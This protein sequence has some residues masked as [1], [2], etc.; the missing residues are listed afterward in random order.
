MKTTVMKT[1]GIKALG[2]L[3]LSLIY[4]YHNTSAGNPA[5]AVEY[6]SPESCKRRQENGVQYY[7]N[8]TKLGCMPCSQNTTFQTVS[9]DGLFYK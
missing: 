8:I 1:M 4:C 6:E 5:F 7:F 2:V 3:L 9:N